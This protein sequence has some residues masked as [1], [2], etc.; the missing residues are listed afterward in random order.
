MLPGWL[1]L[2]GEGRHAFSLV[3]G[4]PARDEGVVFCLDSFSQA[5]VV[6]GQHTVLN[7][8]RRRQRLA[9]ECLTN[10]NRMKNRK[11]NLGDGYIKRGANLKE[12]VIQSEPKDDVN[13]D[14]SNNQNLESIFSQKENLE[15]IIVAI[16]KF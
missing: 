10:M 6:A 7:L 11:S 13:Q 14:F 16:R 1:F 5:K 9:P 12:R 8:R 15:S 4:G 2:V 3:L